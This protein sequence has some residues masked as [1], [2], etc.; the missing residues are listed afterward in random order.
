MLL[1]LIYKLET[2]ARASEDMESK[3]LLLE[4]LR[5]KRLTVSERKAKEVPLERELKEAREDELQ[6]RNEIEMEL[7]T[8]RWPTLLTAL[9]EATGRVHCP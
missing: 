2:H 8:H 3:R 1:S 4:E 5:Q 9:R 7:G 6:V